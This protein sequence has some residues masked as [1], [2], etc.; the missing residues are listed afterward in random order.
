[1]TFET[2]N[3]EQQLLTANDSDFI[4]FF[5][6]GNRIDQLGTEQIGWTAGMKQTVVKLSEPLKAKIK[7]VLQIKKDITVWNKTTLLLFAQMRKQI[8]PTIAVPTAMPEHYQQHKH[9]FI[10]QQKQQLQQGKES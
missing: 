8:A 3:L 10:A 1:M 2:Q 7:E 4:K 6:D 9:A 5:Q